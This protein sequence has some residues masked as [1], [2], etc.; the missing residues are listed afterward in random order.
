MKQKRDSQVL[1]LLQKRTNEMIQRIL[2]R[3]FRAMLL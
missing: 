1:N 2:I 3:L